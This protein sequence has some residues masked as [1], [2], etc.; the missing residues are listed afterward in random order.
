LHRLRKADD[1]LGGPGRRQKRSGD[2][3]RRCPGTPGGEG[4][5]LRD[6]RACGGSAGGVEREIGFAGAH[7]D[8]SIAL[9]A[10]Q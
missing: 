3:R 8:Y 9:S 10:L 5:W 1:G 6:G 4:I 7:P 2:R